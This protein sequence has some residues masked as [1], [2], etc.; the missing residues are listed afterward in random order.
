MDTNL[1]RSLVWIFVAQAVLLVVA[2]GRNLHQ[3][4]P[5]AVAYLRIAGYYA[6]GQFDLAMTGYWGPLLSW[7]MVPLLKL[8]V[9]Q[10]VAA[11]VVMALSGVVFLV[12]AVAV[13]RAFRLPPKALVS[14]ACIAAGYAVFWSVR[15][16]TPDLL[17]AGLVALA[18]SATV[19]GFLSGRLSVLI[20][21]GAWWGLAY[22]A[23]ALALPLA[24]LTC[25]VLAALAARRQ[26]ACGQAARTTMARRLAL[27]WTCCALVAGPWIGVLSLHYGKFTFSTTGPIAHALAGPGADAPYHPAMVTLHQPDAGRVTQW[28][29]PSRMAYRL[30]SPLANGEN[31]QHQL[32]VLAR[33][34]ATMTDWLWGV[35]W[36][37]G[38]NDPRGVAR[39]LPGF[40]LLGLSL[41]GVVG[42]V[43]VLFANRHRPRRVRWSWAAVPVLCLGGLYLPFFVMAEDSRY[44][45]GA[46]PF[47][48]VMVTG[49]W[50]WVSRPERDWARRV[51]R[52]VFRVAMVAFLIPSLMWLSVAI[53]SL[54]N[55]ASH[56]AHELA[57]GLKP[58][59]VSGPLAGS[60]AMP[61]GRTGLYT[62]LLLGE[63]WL[64]DN[65]QAGPEEF[66]AS[67]ARVVVTRRG[68]RQAEALAQDSRWRTMDSPGVPSALRVFIREN[69]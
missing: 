45:Y 47:V 13:F 12:G 31:F 56:A 44:F 38:A 6:G 29:E 64:G 5:D 67:G 36:L 1:R 40:D 11:R 65:E 34:A 35:R 54:P 3:L 37:S 19:E 4:N 50:G 22:L 23:K 8:G 9:A 26:A 41:A 62:A 58:L 10:L 28:E 18:V 61:G 42:G 32:G 53:Y 2:A 63:R 17:M 43:V 69:P 60:G 55:L 27:V 48:W 59:P 24:V 16:I 7:L 14:G 30:W 25:V 49:A 39:M 57:I 66:A 68:S 15:N 52:R 46:L 51:R 33:N 21:A 20:A